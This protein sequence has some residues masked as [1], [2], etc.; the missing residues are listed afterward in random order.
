MEGEVI[1]FSIFEI[2]ALENPVFEARFS[3]VIRCSTRSCMI[4]LGILISIIKLTICQLVEQY[5]TKTEGNVNK[6]IVQGELKDERQSIPEITDGVSKR[7]VSNAIQDQ[8]GQK[9]DA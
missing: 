5:L 2:K 1:W 7:L 8:R 4:F 3:W 9:N 6:K